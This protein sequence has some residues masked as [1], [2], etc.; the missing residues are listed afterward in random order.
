M[1]ANIPDKYDL[2]VIGCGPGGFAAAMR[3][4]DL[5]KH[6]CIIER[7]E[8]GGAGVMWGALASKTMWE[9]AKDYAVAAKIDRGYRSAGLT[10]DYQA[11]RDTVIQAVKEKQYQMLSQIETFS[12]RRWNGPGSLTLKRGQGTFLSPQK[13]ELTSASGPKEQ[14]SARHFLIATG[15]KPRCFPNIE[16]DQTRVFDSDGILQLKKFPKR[17]IIIGAGIIG[18]EY[19]AIFSNFGQTKV[20]LIDHMDR[21]IPYEDE[22]VSDF[23]SENL[24]RNGV[25]IIHSAMLRDIIRHPDC[26]EVIL[27]FADGHSQVIEADAA[28]F[29][30]GRVPNLSSLN[31]DKL[32]IRIL[33]RGCLDIDQNCCCLKD[34]VYAAG[35]VTNHPALVNMAEMEGRYAADH[36]FG[37]TTQPLNYRNMSTIMFFQ[38]AVAAV[39]M[40]EKNCQKKKIPY[41]VGY[42]SN[43]LL[44]RAIAM[45]G[46]NG[47]VKII[48]SDDEDQKILGMRAAGPEVS[49]TIVS[50]AHLMDLGKGIR[51]VLKSVYPHPTI[52]EGIQ[53][54][55]RLLIGRSVYKPYA[56]PEHL[57]I[58]IWHPD[59][60]YTDVSCELMADSCVLE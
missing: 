50:V 9:L 59:K 53:E 52:S 26:L 29:S 16:T 7:G 43:A 45:R 44:P 22:D 34:N 11:V 42:Y 5:G 17:L 31:L 49:S 56:F 48:V 20:C 33:D 54:C 37:V 46:L 47:F 38:P 36:M 57:K 13:I 55:L 10:V 41:R 58:N 24:A 25:K 51:D 39:G 40:N 27:D 15:S 35:D 19:A 23:V 1:S 60:G 30:I 2:C 18:C 12:P 8:I 32:G 21:V 4:L 14:I 6:V 28:L 3:G